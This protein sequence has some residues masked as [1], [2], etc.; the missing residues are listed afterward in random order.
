MTPFA[1]NGAIV[2]ASLLVM[3]ATMAPALS[4]EAPDE[5]TA[6]AFREFSRCDDE[7]MPSL[8]AVLGPQ[9]ESLPSTTRSDGTKVTTLSPPLTVGSAAFDEYFDSRTRLG[10]LGSVRQWGFV[11]R[12]GVN[13]VREGLI[14]LI[15]DGD[16]MV[17]KGGFARIEY[18]D[19]ARWVAVIG[20]GKNGAV[21]PEEFFGA[22]MRAF[23]IAA[24]DGEDQPTTIVK[25]RSAHPAAGSKAG[26]GKPN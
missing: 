13:A 16:H 22:P 9:F 23:V 20:S 21:V 7:T 11:S 5:A 8:G 3:A 19:G 10:E 1:S 4:D 24:D 14:G 25:C 18:F 26:G 2:S 15:A 17:A 6:R 12:Q